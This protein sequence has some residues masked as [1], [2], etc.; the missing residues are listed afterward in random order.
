MA[1]KDRQVLERVRN[2]S[3]LLRRITPNQTTV[4]DALGVT[5]QLMS[6]YCNCQDPDHNFPAALI[7]SHPEAHEILDILVGEI[8]YEMIPRSD[9]DNINGSVTDERD[10]IMILLGRITD[11]EH[12]AER[13]ADPDRK[14]TR[15]RAIKL[16]E[17][18]TEL[19]R[20]AAQLEAEIEHIIGEE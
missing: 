19:R 8:G 6:M 12:K 2:F 1:F 5:R 16:R 10:Q 18:A 17:H 20:A 13:C 11:I 14:L 7:T 9:H 3:A 4:A 15:H